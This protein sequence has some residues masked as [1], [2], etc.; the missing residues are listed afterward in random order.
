MALTL[1]PTVVESTEA[2]AD[3]VE[4]PLTDEQLQEVVFHKYENTDM[5]ISDTEHHD[6]WFE[7]I[8]ADIPFG[9]SRRPR[10]G[11][12]DESGE[13][14]SVGEQ[15]GLVI[16]LMGMAS[17]VF[18]YVDGRYITDEE[19]EEWEENAGREAERAVRWSFRVTRILRT[20]GPELREHAFRTAEQKEATNKA[21]M[22]ETISAAFSQGMENMHS[23]GQHSADAETLLKSVDLEALVTEM[24]RRSEGAAKEKPKRAPRR[25]SK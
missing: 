1:D 22:F 7:Q 13:R 8:V 16:D 4:V 10:V 18:G 6:T 25:Q 11:I 19:T 17:G 14:R 5:H 2:T 20:N 3:G 23:K 21:D 12:A 9:R 15:D 24:E